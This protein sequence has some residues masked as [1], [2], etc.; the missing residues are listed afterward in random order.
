MEHLNSWI[1]LWITK[2]EENEISES[3]KWPIILM[4]NEGRSVVWAVSYWLGVDCKGIPGQACRLLERFISIRTRNVYRQLDID[5]MRNVHQILTTQSLLYV[6]CCVNLAS[7]MCS[8]ALSRG[9]HMIQ[10]YLA[11]HGFDCSCEVIKSTESDIFSTL[12]FQIPLYTSVEVAEI[13]AMDVGLPQDLIEEVAVL[14]NLLEYRRDKLTDLIQISVVLVRLTESLEF[15]SLRMIHI[16]A[17]AV[18]TVII[19]H[20]LVDA[21]SSR[22]TPIIRLQRLTELPFTLLRCIVNS[23]YDIVRMLDKERE[24]RDSKS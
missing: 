14:T 13:I 9:T 23:I 19:Q 6:A 11:E 2:M 5:E 20:N 7:K 1:Y 4:R 12:G 22:P 24:E 15:T 17:G 16:T 3:A 21:T 8:A 18:A 10:E